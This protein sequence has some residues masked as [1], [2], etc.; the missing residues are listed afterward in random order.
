VNY[1]LV[2]TPDA[3]KNYTEAV[4]WYNERNID[5]ASS[6]IIEVENKIDHI[7]TDPK[8]YKNVYKSFRE[9]HLIKFPFSL[10]YF[11]DDIN[12]VVILTAV[13][14]HKRNPKHKYSKPKL[15]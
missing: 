6:L 3:L 9:T 14:H 1:K 12:K 13:F 7:C 4:D 5:V 15:S 10:I 8:R 2:F 11:I